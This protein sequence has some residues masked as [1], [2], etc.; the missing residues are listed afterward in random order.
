MAKKF[1]EIGPGQ[2]LLETRVE[3]VKVEKNIF[4]LKTKISHIGLLG[5]LEK[6]LES[7]FSIGEPIGES[8]Y[9]DML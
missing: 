4:M 6:W 1:L 5:T 9:I 3:I 2:N 7:K 8:N